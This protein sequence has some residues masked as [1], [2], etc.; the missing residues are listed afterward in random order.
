[1]TLEQLDTSVFTLEVTDKLHL[2]FALMYYVLR[3]IRSENIQRELLKKFKEKEAGDTVPLCSTDLLALIL[4]HTL[5]EV[6]ADVCERPQLIDLFLWKIPDAADTIEKTTLKKLECTG[7]ITQNKDK[8]RGKG[9][10][11][12]IR[13]TEEGDV[14]LEGLKKERLAS[15]QTFFHL[16]RMTLHKGNREIINCLDKISEEATRLMF[17]EFAK[18]AKKRRTLPATRKNVKKPRLGKIEEGTI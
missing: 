3:P 7:L 13:I 1:M 18:A 15:I 14:L 12:L 4:I 8:R 6:N 9:S 2:H 10:Q 11:N 17:D 16:V 5:K